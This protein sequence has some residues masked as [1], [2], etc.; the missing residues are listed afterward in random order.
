M[1]LLRRRPASAALPSRLAALVPGRE[2]VLG[3]VPLDEDGRCWAAATAEHL[4]ILD[5]DGVVLSVR[6][7]HPVSTHMGRATAVTRAL[8]ESTGLDDDRL[9]SLLDEA[10]ARP[11]SPTWLFVLAAGGGAALLSI[12]SGAD[13][14]HSIALIF[15][16]AALGGLA[17]RLLAGRATPVAQ[18]FV[19]ALIGGLAGSLSVHLGW[20]SSA[21]LVAVCP[22][23]VLVP[24]PQVLNGCL[25]IARR[26]HDLGLARLAD[27]ALT[28]LAIAGGLVAGMAAW[29]A[30]LPVSASFLAVPLWVD[31]LGAGLVA[32]CY[33]VYFSMPYRTIPWALLAG[34]LGHALHWIAVSR[35]EWGGPAASMAT[36]ALVS[37]ILTP[38]SR[39]FRIPFAGA[40]FAAVVALVP[41]VYFFRATAGLLALP[42]MSGATASAEL[43]AV[44]QDL[45][46]ASL[47][48][49]GMAI[50]LLAPYHLMSRGVGS[51]TD[52]PRP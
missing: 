49:L 22:A 11:V 52:R 32:C 40:G 47:T 27:A 51:G 26:R 30:S 48:V 31:V 19:A 43:L 39:R 38:V 46:T 15:A 9:E 12:I 35:W 8:A 36:C 5:D 37:A 23:M 44:A 42:G 18:V 1:R 13:H 7:I 25:D 17:R 50:G 10:E 29:G 45:T 4:V 33:P 28:I 20:T 41:G 34:G 6:P 2:R 21:R 3:A 14:P 24:G 16:A